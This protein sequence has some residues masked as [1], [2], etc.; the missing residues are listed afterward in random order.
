MYGREGNGMTEEENHRYDEQHTYRPYAR[1]YPHAYTRE[2]MHS[3]RHKARAASKEAQPHILGVQIVICILC[4][5]TVLLL[6]LFKNPV[7]QTIR[8]VLN[9]AL[10]GSLKAQT[11]QV[12][13]YIRSNLPDVRGVFTLSPSTSAASGKSASSGKGTS[14]QPG[15]SASG[16]TA[17]ASSGSVSAS[18]G[19]GGS[20]SSTAATGQGAVAQ[21]QNHTDVPL[22]NV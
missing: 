12:M 22:S 19:S 21:L 7:D 2:T 18:A 9:D 17:S 3:G 14:S 10:N 1:N 13:K 8:R 4:L 6:H 20:V 15:S 16:R 5:S 11:S